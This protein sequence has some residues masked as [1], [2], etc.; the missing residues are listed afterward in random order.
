MVVV[1]VLL[2]APLVLV[3][4]GR[5]ELAVELGLVGTGL[6]LLADG[7]TA[8]HP[9]EREDQERDHEEGDDD[10]RK[11]AGTLPG[12]GAPGRPAELQDAAG[13]IRTHKSQRDN[14]F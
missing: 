2:G 14:G 12:A 13:G 6:E 1:R 5:G 10:D 9:H 3:G 8:S 4:L 7:V 11:H